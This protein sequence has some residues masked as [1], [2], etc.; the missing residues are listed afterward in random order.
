MINYKKNLLIL[1]L[2]A[3]TGIGF[4]MFARPLHRRSAAPVAVFDLGGVL[5]E[6]NNGKLMKKKIGIGKII[7]YV[8]GFNN[9]FKLQK[10]TFDIL[11]QMRGEQ[12]P[13]KGHIPDPMHPLARGL[14]MPEIMIEWQLGLK[15]PT[16][17]LDEVNEYVAHL[18][19]NKHF[20]SG[21]QRRLVHTILTHI[22]DAK[23]RIAFTE[24]IK[25][26]WDLLHWYKKNGHEI[27]IL[28]NMDHDTMGLLQEHYPELF[29]QVNGVV[30]S[31]EV[32][33]MK[34]WP[35]IFQHLLDKFGLQAEQ[36]TFFDDQLENIKSAQNLG[37][38]TV[39]CSSPKAMKQWFKQVKSAESVT[40]P[41]AS[42]TIA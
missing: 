31:A 34:P 30:Y 1:A 39:H 8:L 25:E 2:L 36:C 27:Y 4:A 18:A 42:L 20:S 38:G 40:L 19:Q 12:R 37:F 11:Y 32:K 28:S 33:T 15:T 7:S 23:E 24:P 5:F 13:K 9:P 10:K 29:A 3:G 17:L 35:D 16:E 22:F 26:G 6:V 21:L 14:P 41:A